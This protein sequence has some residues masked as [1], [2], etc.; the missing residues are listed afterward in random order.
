[1][2]TDEWLPWQHAT[3]RIYLVSGDPGHGLD[4]EGSEE[5]A[6]DLSDI[7]V[8]WSL[9]FSSDHCIG[10]EGGRGE[11]K[12]VRTEGRRKERYRE[13]EG[14]RENRQVCIKLKVYGNQALKW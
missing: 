9:V 5:G 14:E 6:D 4:D 11:G 7:W 10:R 2:A 12:E 8:V 3:P 1:M 13:S